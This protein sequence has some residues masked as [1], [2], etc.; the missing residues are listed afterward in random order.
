MYIDAFVAG[1][2]ATLLVEL[3]AFAICVIGCVL[4][5]GNDDYEDHF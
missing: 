2:L 4:R 1:V 3:G 5:G